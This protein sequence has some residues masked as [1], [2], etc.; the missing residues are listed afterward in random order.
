MTNPE[1]ATIG[2]VFRVVTEMNRKLEAIKEVVDGHTVTLA[3]HTVTLNEHTVTLAEHTVT[4]AEHTVTL[5]EH[6]VKL[7]EAAQERQ[8]IR[9][10]VDNDL[11]GQGQVMALEG[12][13]TDV[14][15]TL[16]QHG[17]KIDR[18]TKERA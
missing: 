14:Q 4:L 8:A 7:D 11:A 1:Q 2:D 5:A 3:E 13:L 12:K 15:K 10:V 17:Q 6:T 16:R 9:D 18:L